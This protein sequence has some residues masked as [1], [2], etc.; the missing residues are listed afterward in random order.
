MEKD[1]TKKRVHPTQK[2]SILAE[3][4][5]NKYNKKEG[6]RIVDL[7]GGSGSTLIAS[8]KTKNRCFMMEYEPKYVDIIIQRWENFTG[9]KAIK[10]N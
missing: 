5:I 10:I 9:Q 3:W 6:A 7:Y 2:P 4:F 1:D 8:E